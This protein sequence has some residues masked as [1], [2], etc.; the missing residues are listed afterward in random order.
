MLKDWINSYENL[1]DLKR[2]QKFRSR[3]IHMS[4]NSSC[5][6]NLEIALDF[7]FKKSKVVDETKIPVIFVISCQNFEAYPGVRLN[8]KAYS[9]Y[10]SEQE[11]LLSEG[12]PALIL[13]IQHDFVIKSEHD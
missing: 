11:I 9:A 13:D 3:K 6:R 7:A 2:S 12:C 5:T 4:G 10:S 1:N 8:N